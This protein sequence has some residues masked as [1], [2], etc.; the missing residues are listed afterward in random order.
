MHNCWRMRSAAARDTRSKCK[1]SL[2]EHATS[3]PTRMA[4]AGVATCDAGL[5]ASYDRHTAAPGHRHSH[6]HD[7]TQVNRQRT[8]LLRSLAVRAPGD[9]AHNGMVQRQ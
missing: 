4:R 3:R 8:A 1:G 9:A 2:Y 5:D 7:N 6:S